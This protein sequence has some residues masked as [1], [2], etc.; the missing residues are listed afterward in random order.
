MFRNILATSV[1]LL[2][3]ID[4][5]SLEKDNNNMNKISEKLYAVTFTLGKKN[6]TVRLY[7]I[8]RFH[9]TIPAWTPAELYWQKKE[10]L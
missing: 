8:N 4:I 2:F 6:H 7:V 3:G 1:A 5:N 10:S 9:L